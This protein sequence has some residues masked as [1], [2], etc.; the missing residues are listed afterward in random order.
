MSKFYFYPAGKHLLPV[1]KQTFGPG[2]IIELDPEQAEKIATALNGKGE[3]AIP[4]QEIEENGKVVRLPCL[5]PAPAD[6]R[7]VAMPVQV[8]K[9]IP[10]SVPK[11]KEIGKVGNPQVPGHL[12]APPKA[13]ESDGGEV[14]APARA[15]GKGKAKGKAQDQEIAEG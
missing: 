11:P 10:R 1:G 9:P 8:D 13:E 6:A 2:S 4:G 14:I 5:V 12:L 15:T 7:I 3:L